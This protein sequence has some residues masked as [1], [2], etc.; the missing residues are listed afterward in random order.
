MSSCLRSKYTNNK[1]NRFLA[2]VYN[3]ELLAD[4][5]CSSDIPKMCLFDD[6]SNDQEVTELNLS[7]LPKM[8]T[9]YPKKMLISFSEK[10]ESWNNVSIKDTPIIIF[11][12]NF[13]LTSFYNCSLK[14]NFLS[15]CRICFNFTLFFIIRNFL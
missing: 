13:K 6:Q 3:T 10:D 12:V 4:D 15:Y 5:T 14:I 8:N 9:F 2:S 1:R 7:L 11:Q